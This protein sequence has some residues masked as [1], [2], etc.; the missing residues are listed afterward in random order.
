MCL[1]SIFTRGVFA[2][3]YV[4][5]GGEGNGMWVVGVCYIT[6]INKTRLLRRYAEDPRDAVVF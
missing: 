2:W 4:C 3:M 6:V 1:L 5:V